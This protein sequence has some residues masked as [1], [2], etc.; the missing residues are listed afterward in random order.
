MSKTRSE[1]EKV[2]AA[3]RERLAVGEH[4][5]LHEGKQSNGLGMFTSVTRYFASLD[6]ARAVILEWLDVGHEFR[7][8][9][10]FHPFE[11]GEAS[12]WMCSLSTWVDRPFDAQDV[13]AAA[14]RAT[15]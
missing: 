1:Y 2:V 7:L 11:P 12:D 15:S 6:D 14:A 8:S 4:A 10:Y 5:Y 3:F 13:A 9:V